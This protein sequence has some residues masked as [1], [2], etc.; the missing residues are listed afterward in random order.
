MPI[1]I[2]L[3]PTTKITGLSA[4]DTEASLLLY[5]PLL[6]PCPLERLWFVFSAG[7]KSLTIVH[8]HPSHFITTSELILEDF[9]ESQANFAS[10]TL[11]LLSAVEHEMTIKL[12]NN[13]YQENDGRYPSDSP[14][15][16]LSML[17]FSTSLEPLNVW[18]LQS[19]LGPETNSSTFHH[20][21]EN[22]P[23]WSGWFSAA[24]MVPQTK[25][26]ESFHGVF[27]M[28]W[29]G[30][31]NCIG[32]TLKPERRSG[33]F[34]SVLA[35]VVWERTK[36]LESC[37]ECEPSV[38]SWTRASR[39]QVTRTEIYVFINAIYF[40]FWFSISEFIIFSHIKTGVQVL[41]E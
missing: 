24:Q 30:E 8:A 13:I 34:W 18:T 2:Q 16:S 26:W 40:G 19:G 6:P 14:S 38:E 39:S 7:S 17:Q 22:L 41:A 28:E 1:I 21:V 31:F 32:R 9:R 36:A 10:E 4:L 20:N 27:F 15:S 25:A 3:R 33:W 37:D 5:I 35:L 29:N 23:T 11:I 12:M